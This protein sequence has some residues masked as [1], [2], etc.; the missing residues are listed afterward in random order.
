MK[1]DRTS[2]CALACAAGLLASVPAFG[3][4]SF[5]GSYS[6]NFD[7]LSNTGTANAWANDSTLPGWIV[8]QSG[9]GS[10]SN[11]RDNTLTNVINYRADSG[12]SNAGALYSWGATG[13]TERALGSVA[14]GTPGDFAYA[15]VLQN[16]TG[17]PL[18][19]FTLS[20]NI[21][22]WRQGGQSSSSPPLGTVQMHVLDYAVFALAPTATDLAASNTAGYTAPGGAWDAV[23]PVGTVAV[24]GAMDGNS[25]G[26]AAGAGGTAGVAWLPGEFLVIRWW[27]DN[28]A[29][30]DHGIGI[31]DL[32]ITAVPT[33]GALG[34][35]GLG[36]LVLSRRRR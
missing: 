34:L 13:D 15:L 12:G 8:L 11:T 21:E 1:V 30:N 5:L 2:S 17:S 10:V 3:A 28:N 35:L 36:G 25:T 29:G 7:S 14:S 24:G 32:T 31:D 33:P 16:D 22:Q 6:Q 18:T 26:L 4:V 20:Y 9:S 19:S 23:G 27:D